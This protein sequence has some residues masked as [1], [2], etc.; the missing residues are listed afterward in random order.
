MQNGN[1][2]DEKKED[3][4]AGDAPTGEDELDTEDLTTEELEELERS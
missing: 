4:G 2:P 3:V 1:D